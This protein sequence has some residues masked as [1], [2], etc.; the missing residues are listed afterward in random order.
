MDI[1]TNPGYYGAMDRD[2]DISSSSGTEDTNVLGGRVGL[3]DQN[4]PGS[5]FFSH[6]MSCW[7]P[8]VI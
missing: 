8:R 7:C 2:G 6:V 4:A 3:S 1:N 5:G